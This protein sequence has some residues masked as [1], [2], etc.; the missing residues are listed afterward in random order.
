MLVCQ[1]HG[2][3]RES[4]SKETSPENLMSKARGGMSTVVCQE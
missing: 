1:K 4:G 3:V 2:E